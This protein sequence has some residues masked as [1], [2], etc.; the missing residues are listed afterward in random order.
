LRRSRPAALQIRDLL[1]TGAYF[2]FGCGAAAPLHYKSAIYCQQAHILALV[3][4]QPPFASLRLCITNLS[5]LVILRRFC[6]V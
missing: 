4:A 6:F 1:P 2:D 5:F 3:A